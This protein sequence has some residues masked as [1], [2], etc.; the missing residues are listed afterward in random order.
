MIGLG[1]LKSQRQ[2]Q[3]LRQKTLKVVLPARHLEKLIM[4]IEDARE[5]KRPLSKTIYCRMEL[6]KESKEAST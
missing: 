3:M 6:S 4:G 2:K 5:Y 1:Y